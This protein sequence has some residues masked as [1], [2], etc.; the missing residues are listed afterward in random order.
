MKKVA[1]G[2]WFT[3]PLQLSIPVS[4]RDELVVTLGGH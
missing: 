1:A 4:H 3:L 2:A